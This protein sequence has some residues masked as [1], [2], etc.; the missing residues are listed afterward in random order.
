MSGSTGQGQPPATGVPRSAAPRPRSPKV[1][2]PR[3]PTWF[4]STRSPKVVQPRLPTW[5]GS[6]ATASSTRGDGCA[7]RAAERGDGRAPRAAEREGDL[8]AEE[9]TVALA[10]TARAG[11]VS[12]RWDVDLLALAGSQQDAVD[13]LE[14]DSSGGIVD[15]LQEETDTRAGC[16]T[17]NQEPGPLGQRV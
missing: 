17:R 11:V 15:G 7:P 14:V 3:L 2:Q 9:E 12:G 4:G 16:Y 5:F 6:T 8:A 1:V 10:I 13:L